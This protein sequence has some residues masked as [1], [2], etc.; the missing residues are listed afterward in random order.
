MSITTFL[1]SKGFHTFEGYSQEV[2]QQVADLIE[3]TS[4]ASTVMEI[5][6][7]AGHSAEIF[8]KNNEKVKVTSFDIGLHDYLSTA[9]QYIDTTFPCRHTLVLGDSTITIPDIVACKTIT[10]DVIFIDGGHEYHTA[11][12]DLTNC[13]RLATPNTI[14]ILDDTCFTHGWQA[15]HTIGPTKAWMECVANGVV[16]Q[17][18]TK[19]YCH[20]R[21][22]SWGR[23]QSI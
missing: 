11:I 18:Q 4:D 14:V 12:A 20:G 5:G 7:N 16:Q 2:Q 15:G 1:H 13:R 8:L 17:I 6:F 21:G 23:Y 22:M 10:F 19:D 9:K 3:L